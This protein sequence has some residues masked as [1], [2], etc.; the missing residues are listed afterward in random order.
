MPD[1]PGIRSEEVSWNALSFDKPTGLRVYACEWAAQVMHLM[2]AC[3]VLANAPRAH[4]RCFAATC[5]AR[6][7]SM[8]VPFVA[9]VTGRSVEACIAQIPSGTACRWMEPGRGDAK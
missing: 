6:A 1:R 9:C 3:C 7:D 2:R 8:R 4:R 5:R